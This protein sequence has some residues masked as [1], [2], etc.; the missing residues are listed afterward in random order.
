METTHIISLMAMSIA[1]IIVI[2]F[3]AGYYT[4]KSTQENKEEII[5]L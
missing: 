3:G 1:S 4:A 2:S 5:D